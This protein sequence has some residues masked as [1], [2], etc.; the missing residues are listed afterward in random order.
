[1][2]HLGRK[3]KHYFI[4]Q[5]LPA[6]TF[7]FTS[8]YISGIRVLQ[9][10]R[11]IKHSFIYSLDKDVILPSF[12][13]KN[14]QIRGELE[15]Q[16]KSG[17]K[18]LGTDESKAGFLLPEM[19]QKT[20][21][22]SFES[23]PTATQERDQLVRFRV[24][25]QMPMIPDDAR[26]IIKSFFTGKEYRVLVTIARTS[27]IQEYED[28]FSQLGV[29]IRNVGI[30]SLALTDL[31][32]FEKN[33]DILVVNIEYDSMSL[34]SIL[35]SKVALYR[36]KQILLESTNGRNS[37]SNIKNIVQEIEKT[38]QFLEDKEK[39][40]IKSIW[41]RSGNLDDSGELFL[42]LAGNLDFELKDIASIIAFKLSTSEKKML[43]PL[44][45]QAYERV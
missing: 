12:S 6:M 31:F 24:K 19:S 11:D 7:Q 40:S 18:K 43:S 5:P 42:E 45:G 30:P 39:R 8:R 16:L 35:D 20:F 27:I 14:I 33:K 3:I 32:D 38:V 22:F 36:Q 26:I 10:E 23:L 29:K 15:K 4:Q 34:V 28:L 9:K 13:Q 41:I 2:I 17:L 1:M 25:K 37:L 21:V 44:I